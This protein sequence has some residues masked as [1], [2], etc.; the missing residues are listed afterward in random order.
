MIGG[1]GIGQGQT[2]WQLWGLACRVVLFAEFINSMI[3][4]CGL[5]C[6][7]QVVQV[8]RA[9]WAFLQLR[10]SFTFLHVMDSM[11]VYLHDMINIVLEM[12]QEQC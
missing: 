7:R 12:F 3:F 9:R 6:L 5:W 1:A 2:A 4:L 11:I 8:A 10:L